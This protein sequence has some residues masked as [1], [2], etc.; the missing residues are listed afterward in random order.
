MMARSILVT[1]IYLKATIARI[2][3]TNDSAALT[4]MS[5]DVERII[6]GFR[7]LHEIWVITIQVVIAGWM[8]YNRVGVVLV[9]PIGLV[10]VCTAG[11]MALMHFTGDS[12]RT[13]MSSVQKRVGLTAVVIASM[14]NLKISGLTSAVGNFVQKLRVEELAA[15]SRFR[16]IFIVA[17]AL[18]FVPQLIGPPLTFAFTQQTLDA[19]KI[20]TSLAFLT[21]LTSPLSEIFQALPSSLAGIAC[22]GRIQTFLQCETQHDFRQVLEEIKI[23]DH[24]SIARLAI[25]DGNFGWEAEKFVLQN[26]NTQ[27]LNSSLTVVVGPVGSGKS[28][29]CTTLLGEIP[30]SEGSVVSNT[31]F[32]HVGY[33]SQSA[34]LSNGSVRD[35]IVGFCP[36]NEER[37]YEVINATA[38][39]FDLNTLP[40][41]DKTNIGSDGIT[42]SGGQRQRVALAR[43]LY[44]GC[45]F[46]VLDDIFSGLDADTEEQ[47]FQQV[48][49]PNGL[50]RQRRT[51]VVL[52]THSV[53]HLPAAD[54][55]I[56][57][58]EGRITEQGSF[59]QLMSSRG[60][61]QRLGIE[62][63]SNG[64]VSSKHTTLQESKSQLWTTKTKA[65]S[66]DAATDLSR[67]VGDK[68]V[69]KHYIKS[70]GVSLAVLS[71]FF[72]ALWGLFTNFPTICKLAL[73]PYSVASKVCSE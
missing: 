5:T 17:A 46:I 22:L 52:C 50:L 67:Q 3:T 40:H 62:D 35:N 58:E 39:S 51:T 31:K 73:Q 32:T 14:K 4:L 1:E 54:H 68:T 45:E 2:G 15:G 66:L 18:G 23:T 24:S 7:A 70:M 19:S 12:Q 56:V 29:L 53:K 60:Y 64:E 57:L 37:Y 47:V 41:G 26:I 13:W 43:A 49:G 11:L 65:L 48:F 33:C 6:A 44:L 16:V 72:A 27:I 21:L 55:I 30:F 71:L 63:S 36:F 28:T 34:F 25:E 69:Y 59:V 9:A 38:L 61:V 8:L 42:L 20:F 10:I